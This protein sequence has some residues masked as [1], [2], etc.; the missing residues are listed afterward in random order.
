MTEIV[1]LRDSEG[2]VHYAARESKAV[3][4]GLADGS[5]T[6][7]DGNNQPIGLVDT[8]TTEPP[9]GGAGS[10]VDAWREYGISQG[11]AV[12]DGMTRDDVIAAVDAAKGA[13]SEAETAESSD[14]QDPDP[15]DD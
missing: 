6:E 12:S 7:L 1:R 14:D 8:E 2:R 3:V 10:G 13:D 15:S 5:F 11:V 9:R 4:D